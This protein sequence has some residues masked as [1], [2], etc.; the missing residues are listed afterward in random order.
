MFENGANVRTVLVEGEVVVREGRCVRI[1]EADVLREAQ[2]LASEL[3][4][5]DDEVLAALEQ[6][7]P[8]IAKLLLASLARRTGLNRFA[9][10]R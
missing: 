5:A 2:A 10:L 6:D 1:N 3:G 4:R 8:H 7:A 9:D